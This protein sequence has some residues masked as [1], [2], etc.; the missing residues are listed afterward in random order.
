MSILFDCGAR[1][2]VVVDDLSGTFLN[3]E[4]L[5]HWQNTFEVIVT[6]FCHVDLAGRKFD[7][8]FHLAS[9]VGSLG[10]MEY[11]GQVAQNIINLTRRA[12]DIALKSRARLSFVSSSEV[13]ADTNEKSE[14]A[15]LFGRS[16]TGTR[17]EYAA[18]KLTAEVILKS[19]DAVHGLDFYICRPFNLIG[20][21]QSSKLGFVV[22]RFIDAALNGEPI[23]VHGDGMQ[24]RSFCHVEDFVRGLLAIHFSSF[25]GGG[26]EFGKR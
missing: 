9:P 5:S 15:L 20:E 6:D 18:G 2:V 16:R 25:R 12:A 8:I 7:D 1:R 10:I 11:T 14:N 26:D 13:Y 24:R 17:A 19:L 4:Q 21:Q 3:K 22:P 23:E